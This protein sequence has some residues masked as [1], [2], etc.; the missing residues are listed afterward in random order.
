[1]VVV[2][3]RHFPDF[4]EDLNNLS[5]NRKT[6]YYEVKELVFTCVSMFLLKRG[7]RNSMNNC[8]TSS[9]FVK[10][11]QKIFGV[12]MAHGD[13]VNKF[14]RQFND[15]ELELV[16]KKMV[17]CI[18][19][20]KILHKFL[21][22]G[23]YA[24][25][26]DGTT[27][28]SFDYEPFPNCLKVEH[29]GG[30]IT[31]LVNVVE[32]KIICSNGFCISLAT[33]WQENESNYDKQDC[34]MKAFVRMA[35]KIKNLYPRLPI[36]ILADGLYPN[37]TVFSICKN[38]GWSYII[39]LKDGNLK[40]VQKEI[41][42]LLFSKQFDAIKIQKLK[43]SN[44][45]ITD[46]IMFMNNLS[47]KTHTINYVACLETEVDKTTAIAKENNFA[48]ITDMSITK[49][50]AALI[51]QF[52]RWRWKIENEGFNVQ[53]NSDYN[54]THK[55]SRR[56][57]TAMKNY[58]QCLQI[59][60]IINQL[61]EKTQKIQK[62]LQPKITIKFLWLCLISFFLEGSIE[63]GDIQLKLNENCHLKY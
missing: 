28:H 32:A 57:F 9:T 59:A 34:E 16:K 49:E 63:T 19:E 35:K 36:C 50:N 61:T 38:Y 44:K 21:I 2:I 26:I 27:V 15:A 42:N 7:S 3:T 25:A 1:M 22:N 47:Y 10:N 40:S 48:H 33:Q 14:L 51:S 41:D 6:S 4:F 39:T 8:R 45:S 54:L 52:G 30:K 5:D 11:Y 58:Y 17:Q 55:Y 53:K 46:E 13:T 31:W 56:N 24:V 23:Q 29:K 62:H 60:H 18:I 37:D 12:E 20:K 43:T